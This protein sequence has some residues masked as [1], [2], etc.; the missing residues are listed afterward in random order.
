M[1]ITQVPVDADREE[2]FEAVR[3]SI[4]AAGRG[5]GYV[6]APTNSHPHVSVERLRWLV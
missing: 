2:G 1:D 4:A 6:I 3:R 5:G